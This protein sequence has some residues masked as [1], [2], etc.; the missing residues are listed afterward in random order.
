MA[1][2]AR[3]P[4]KFGR[5]R[6]ART[7]TTA[8]ALLTLTAATRVPGRARGPGRSDASAGGGAQAWHA[9]RDVGDV[10]E[11][12]RRRVRIDAEVEVHADTLAGS[13]AGS[14]GSAAA[15]ESELVVGAHER[16]VPRNVIA[17]LDVAG[18]M[19]RFRR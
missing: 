2:D 14:R 11:R 13:D 10:R 1:G 19:P 17:D 18:R 7:F 16:R 12:A 15:D 9:G 4:V 6:L 8:L 5:I 3:Y